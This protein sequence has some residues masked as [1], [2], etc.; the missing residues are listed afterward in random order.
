[1]YFSTGPPL[2]AQMVPQPVFFLALTE[3]L[4]G[5]EFYRLASSWAYL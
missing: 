2:K 1:M 4:T 5:D 3:F